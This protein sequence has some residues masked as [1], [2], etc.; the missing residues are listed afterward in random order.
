LLKKQREAVQRN[1]TDQQIEDLSRASR[2]N[3]RREAISTKETPKR[4]AVSLMMGLGFLAVGPSLVLIYLSTRPL[5]RLRAEPPPE[6]LDTPRD[7]NAKRRAA[8]EQLARAYWSSA[9]RHL[10]P[11][12]QFGTKLPDEPLPEFKIEDKDS[13]ENLKDD[14]VARARYWQKLRQIWILPQAWEKSNGWNTD[15]IRKLSAVFAKDG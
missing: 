2:T 14:P 3:F 10:Q 15:W 1:A 4:G 11:S 12:Y 6:F 13:P 7:W 8:E 5:M 9:V